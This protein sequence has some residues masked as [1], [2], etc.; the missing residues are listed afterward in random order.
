[1]VRLTNEDLDRKLNSSSKNLSSEQK[2]IFNKIAS[3]TWFRQYAKRSKENLNKIVE[4]VKKGVKH[5]K[6]TYESGFIEEGRGFILPKVKKSK[7][8]Q[9]PKTKNVKV[10]TQTS[11]KKTNVKRKQ[12]VVERQKKEIAP[13][14][15]QYSATELREGKGSKRAREW[16]VKH[17][18][19]E[20]DYT[21]S[22]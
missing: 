12:R 15:R 9:E 18:I 6:Y 20:G 14:G 19:P 13:S 5:G 17:G 21:T 8:K 11:K 4:K 2:Q 10:Q 3:K 22:R 16:R 1:M 7:K